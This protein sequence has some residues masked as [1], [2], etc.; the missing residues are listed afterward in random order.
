MWALAIR[1]DQE[2]PSKET[3]SVLA[4]ATRSEDLALVPVCLGGV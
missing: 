1:E 3:P 4:L 2:T